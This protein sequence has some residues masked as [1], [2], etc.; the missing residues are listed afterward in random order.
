MSKLAC[1]ALLAALLFSQVAF[2]EVLTSGEGGFAI[3]HT[4]ET[5]ASPEVVYNTMT[6]HIDEWW[7]GAHSWSADA[8]NLYIDPQPGGCFCERLPNGG[9][10][11][12]LR[13]IYLSPGEE[14]RFDGALGPLQQMAV[15]G[16]M[17]W[18]IVPA[19]GGGST[20]SFTYFVH[21]Y[22]EGGF[23]QLAPAVDGV[24]GEQLSRLA[25]RLAPGE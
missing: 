5:P 3:N 16:R 25:A 24:I 10:V 21:G 2:A 17:I 15:S 11:E 9:Q 12:H 20:V 14:I 18:K 23:Q 4:V 22:T 8:S 6:G 7:N 19:E 1:G 13:I